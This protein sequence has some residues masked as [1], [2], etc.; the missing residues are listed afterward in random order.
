MVQEFH[1]LRC[2]SCHTFQV[3]QVKK[4]KKWACKLCGEKQSLIKVY[5]QGS[6][7]DCRHHVQKLN[8][9]QGEVEQAANSNAGLNS[10]NE[11]ND[12]TQCSGTSQPH[13]EA[14]QSCWIKYLEEGGENS[15]EEE[16]GS[17]IYTDPEHFYPWNITS[18]V[19]KRKKMPQYSCDVKEQD[20]N[21]TI[22]NTAKKKRTCE[23]LVASKRQTDVNVDYTRDHG[24]TLLHATEE[25]SCSTGK[26]YISAEKEVK[27]NISRT[28][29]LQKK[30]ANMDPTLNKVQHN[31]NM[32]LSLW[33]SQP[34]TSLECDSFRPVH[35]IRLS[36]HQPTDCAP[37][38]SDRSAVGKPRC[39][40]FQTDEDFDENY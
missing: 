5:G 9:L 23:E 19:R 28:H 3:H 22:L 32:G 8:L 6:G 4:S 40:I 10:Q 33:S 38:P 15:D 17:L 18:E 26:R 14:P 16:D 12:S 27:E 39:S 36:S 35:D 30:I 24:R 34:K 31:Q 13:A 21:T 20:F 37:N 25:P 1:V 2:F 7:A 11:E 29:D